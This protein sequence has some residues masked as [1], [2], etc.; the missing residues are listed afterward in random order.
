M[1]PDILA[2]PILVGREQ[3]LEELTGFLTSA[4]E[5]KG[6]TV[7]ISGEAGSGKT[8]L[9]TEFLKIA[10]QKHNQLT[11]L[12]GWCL[13]DAA[14]PYFPF[15]EA[16]DSY[17]STNQAEGMSAINQNIGL[18]SWFMSAHQPETRE[19][20]A[21]M[22][23]QVWRD[24]AFGA[25]SKE[26]LFIS[27]KSPLILVLEDIHWADSASLS[28]LHYLARQVGS[29]RILILASFRSEELKTNVKGRSNALSKVLLLLG[30]YDLYEEIKLSNLGFSDVGRIA[31]SMLGGNVQSELVEKITTDS[32][33]NALFVVE[34]LR[35]L[36]QQGNLSKK[37]QPMALRHR[38]HR[39]PSKS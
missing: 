18:K 37:E 27:E 7:F 19:K 20:Q 16:F 31:E 32:H 4:I 11:V 6:T 36:Y 15:V 25:V 23:P 5:G 2:E 21:N 34:S 30:R 26:L 9:L 3:E 35:M 33:G 38:K 39:N 28:L 14:I 29:E 17:F 24:Q 8:R 22:T 10:K 12:T 13:S 1:S